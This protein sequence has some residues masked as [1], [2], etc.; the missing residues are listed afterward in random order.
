MGA[1]QGGAGTV[2]LSPLR[3]GFLFR[4]GALARFRFRLRLPML[5]PRV[6]TENAGPDAKAMPAL[7]IGPDG[8]PIASST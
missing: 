4:L 5:W 3:W 2:G 1:P 6:C 8:Q 7:V